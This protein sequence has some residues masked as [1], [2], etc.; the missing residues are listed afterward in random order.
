MVMDLRKHPEFESFV[1]WLCEAAGEERLEKLIGRAEQTCQAIESDPK[2]NPERPGDD[3]GYF[4][5]YW[6]RLHSL[7][8]FIAITKGD[9]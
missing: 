1:D 9:K 7:R 4:D 3:R 5:F 6:R 8:E 2:V